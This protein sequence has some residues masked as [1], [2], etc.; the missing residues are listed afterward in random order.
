MH[1]YNSHRGQLG[2]HL[3]DK[4]LVDNFAGGG[5]ASTAMEMAFGRPVDIAIN[6][7]PEAIDM[8]RVNHPDTEHY[9]ESIW[10]VDIVK[11]CRGR[12]VEWVHSS[13][14]CKHHSK[15]RG[16]KPMDK[17]IRGLAWIVPKWGILKEPDTLSLENVEEFKSWGPLLPGGHACPDNKGVTFK[18]FQLALTTG[19]KPNQT[20]CKMPGLATNYSPWREAVVAMGIE[21]KPKLKLK[22]SK[23]LNYSID[24]KEV[25]ACKNNAPT[26]R[27]RLFMLAKKDCST[28]HWAKPT[29]GKPDSIEVRSGK[30]KPYRTAA[31]CIDWSIPTRSIF[32]RK[33]PLAQKTMER[34]ARG[35]KKFVID[36]PDPFIAP[37]NTVSFITECAN[38]S[39]Q[40]NM[41]ID[42]PLRT[43]TAQTKGG[44]FALVTSHLIKL[45]NGCT[46]S[47][48]SEPFPTITA[49]GNQ[50][51]EVRA[52]LIKYYGNEKDGL[53][54]DEPLHTITTNDRFGL[55]TI[56]GTNYQIADIGLR[57]FKPH[58]LYK[59]QSFPA[60]YIHDRTTEGKKLS[61]RAQVRMCGNSVAPEPFAALIRANIN[62]KAIEQEQAA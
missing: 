61:I 46:G 22:L 60:G 29:H 20:I 52:F 62:V 58:E 47:S 10:A 33:R 35:L 16:G 49:G 34:I 50:L 13:P 38:A 15:A 41:A 24:W 25:I 45:R 42:E 18:A 6:H 55:V 12:E 51:G 19:I 48:L 27:K 8:H 44:T 14:D 39:N 2:L 23:G 7:D 4:L 54:V 32:N 26:T 11:V 37:V 21:H 17:N 3:P 1:V 56:H 5:G 30:L 36:N 57:M 28:I 40:R 9:C 53:G 59:A 31:E 43:I